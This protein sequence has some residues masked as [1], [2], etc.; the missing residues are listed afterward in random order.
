MIDVALDEDSA[1]LLAATIDTEANT[2]GLENADI[3]SDRR[4]I[5]VNFEDLSYD[6]RGFVKINLWFASVV[7][8][9]Q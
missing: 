7:Q 5:E 4:H 2:I 8:D 1:L 6:E 3:S 9:I